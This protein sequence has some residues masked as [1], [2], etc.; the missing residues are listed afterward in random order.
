MSGASI[1]DAYERHDE[2]IRR[3]IPSHYQ[4]P[5]HLKQAVQLASSRRPHTAALEQIAADGCAH[6]AQRH[7]LEK[8]ARP[9]S[10]A[11]LTG[12]QAGLFISPVLAAYKALAAVAAAQ[13]IETTTGS[14]A[15]PVFW[16]QAEDHDFEEI[17]STYLLSSTDTVELVALPG[18]HP[19]HTSVFTHIL[20]SSIDDVMAQVETRCAGQPFLPS[21]M[22]QLRAAYRPGISIVSA[23]QLLM[24]EWFG[25]FGL[26]TF[27][28]TH[29][30]VR[31]ALQPV[32]SKALD[33]SNHIAALLTQRNALLEQT[34]LTPTVH[35]RDDSPLFFVHPDGASGPRYRIQRLPTGEYGYVGTERPALAKQKLLGWLDGG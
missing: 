4:D 29:A 34:G 22:N 33:D 12:Q 7:A 18:D 27:Q 11:V 17:R 5:A 8:L 24:N 35:V 26:L 15:V 21:I 23:F 2:S 10:V 32:F 3:F 25:K 19:P 30:D 31:S 6:E 28:P 20:G 14:P 9:G 13:H 1:A 16:I